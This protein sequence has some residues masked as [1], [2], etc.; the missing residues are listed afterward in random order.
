[1]SPDVI[2]QIYK[3]EIAPFLANTE[4]LGSKRMRSLG[5]TFLQCKHIAEA[6]RWLTDALAADPDDLLAHNALSDSYATEIRTQS[7]FPD[8]DK[9]LQHKNVVI[10]ELKAGR[11]LY[12][13]TE[14]N[15]SR[16]S[17]ILEKAGWLRELKRYEESRTILYDLLKERP[18]DD[19]VRLEL[20]RTLCHCKRFSEVVELVQALQKEVDEKTNITATSRFL[21]SHAF[22]DT[23]HALVVSAFRQENRFGEVQSYY[24]LA[25]KDCLSGDRTGQWRTYYLTDQL[26]SILFKFGESS[27]DR[28]EAINL[29]ERVVKERRD[30]MTQCIIQLCKAYLAQALKAGAGSLVADTMLAKIKTFLP[31]TG[32]ESEEADVSQSFVR[33]LLARYYRAVDDPTKAQETLRPDME[34]ALKLLFDNDKE[35]DWQG[36]RKLADALMD[37][38][39]FKDAQAA[40]SLIQPT[41]GIPHL[42]QHPRSPTVPA[43]P[44]VPSTEVGPPGHAIAEDAQRLSAEDVSSSST[45]PKLKRANTTISPVGP[46]NYYC[47]GRCGT[48]WTYADNFY[49]CSECIDIQ[50]SEDCLKKLQ[51]G[52]LEREVCDPGHR[53][54][55]VPAWTL[56]NAEL[57]RDGKVLVGDA[58]RDITV[59]LEEIKQA[60]DLDFVDATE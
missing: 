9:A 56:V 43:N 22:N 32:D 21:Q 44:D 51:A 12:S 7:I 28:E 33:A 6:I 47:D 24:R 46:L 13:S 40:W 53:F 55:H 38:G 35:N 26:A 30:N 27:K 45:P 19:E 31:T 1:M 23:C 3:K 52:Q 58:V 60:W 59:W 4:D 37:F 42:L 2:N 10:E 16:Q 8:W 5:V 29:W 54:L 48:S 57:A 50:F 34:L 36:Y 14:P 20:V 39:A 15:A 25:I 11:R 49:I 17:A 41:Q 18:E